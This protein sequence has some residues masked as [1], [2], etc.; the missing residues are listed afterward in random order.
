MKKRKLAKNEYIDENGHIKK[1]GFF[2]WILNY[3]YYY[4]SYI[5][6]GLVVIGFFIALYFSM[7][8]VRPDLRLYFCVEQELGETQF[9][10]LCD[11][12]YEYIIDVDGDD[13]V[14]MEPVTLVL[15]ENPATT[16]ERSAYQS[17]E[18]A[19]TDDDIV[20]FIADE[21]G[22]QYLMEQEMLRDLAFFGITSDDA[23]RLRL[24]DTA[25]WDGVEETRS[26]YLVMKNIPDERYEDF[27]LSTI[28]TMVVDMCYK[29]VGEPV[30]NPGT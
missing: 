18:K 13:V 6:V 16:S 17:L 19:F 25:L 8:T 4:R 15:T 10:T 11:N 3:G 21:Y 5:I 12:L 27:Y 26:F 30:Q 1:K 29:L 14:Y 7:K 9:Q 23:Y 24:N 2:S 22:Y 20:C 28:T